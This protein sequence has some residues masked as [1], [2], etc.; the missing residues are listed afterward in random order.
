MASKSL[1]D[2]ERELMGSTTDHY[3]RDLQAK[4]DRKLKTS[5]FLESREQAKVSKMGG[6][7][8]ESTEDKTATFAWQFKANCLKLIVPAF[9]TMLTGTFTYPIAVRVARS[10]PFRLR[11]FY[12]I[13]AGIA[14]FLAFIHVNVFAAWHQYFKIKLTEE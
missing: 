12:A 10:R 14:P 4:L 6:A 3:D 7:L 11:G 1:K 13:H 2:L 8:L 9:L 5:N